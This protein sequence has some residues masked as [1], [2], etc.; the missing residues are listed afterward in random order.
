MSNVSGFAHCRWTV[1]IIRNRFVFPNFRN[2]K[3][4]II[5]LY[6]NVAILYKR[7]LKYCSCKIDLALGDRITIVEGGGGGVGI[8][9]L[10]SHNFFTGRLR[11]EEKRA[12]ASTWFPGSLILLSGSVCLEQR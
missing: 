3:I 12:S 2:G 4:Y 1:K 11:D 10:D 6:G 5:V 8:H 7:T 9:S